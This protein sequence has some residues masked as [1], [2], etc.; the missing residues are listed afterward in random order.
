V[1]IGLTRRVDRWVGVPLC[2]LLSLVPGSRRKPRSGGSVGR[3]LVIMLSEMG[4]QVLAVPMFRELRRKYPGAT[5]HALV[6]EKNRELLEL[7]DVVPAENIVTID[8]ATAGRFVSSSM[9][10]VRTLRRIG[11]DTVI[12]AELFTRVGSI[13]AYLSGAKTRVGFHRHT[14][15]GLYRGDFINRPVVYNPYQHLSHQLLTLAGAVDSDS[16]PSGKRAVTAPLPTV[17]GIVFPQPEIDALRQRLAADFPGVDPHRLVLIQ[18]GGGLLPI[19]AWPREHYARL[20]S[21]LIEAGYGVAVIG[22]AADREV[23]R[24]IS[25][26]VGDSRLLDLT[27]YTRTVRELLLLF[28]L[29]PLLIANDGGPAQFSALTPIAA[30]ILYGP[31]T[32]VLYGSLNPRAV[33]LHLSLSCSPCLTA[34][35]HRNSPCDGDTRC[36]KEITPSLVLDKALELLK[37]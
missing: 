30:V 24:S 8:D 28:H 6:F 16:L 12:D 32:P 27:G 29:A 3:V 34:Y 37:G 33:C 26:A 4:S 36:L 13:L 23:A 17:P 20:A 21:G 10:A 11:I 9:G 14:Q 7:L 18:P 22:P 5:L 15:E 35:N 1:D 19:R 25:A 31:E 2:R